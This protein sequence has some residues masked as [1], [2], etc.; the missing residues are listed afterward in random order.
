MNFMTSHTYITYIT[1]H[2]FTI[3]KLH[4][5][6]I[7]LC[8]L[9]PVLTKLCEKS[10]CPAES[11]VFLYSFET[12]RHVSI[13]NYHGISIYTSNT[14]ST[15][16]EHLML[17]G[18][19]KNSKKQNDSFTIFADCKRENSANVPDQ[20]SKLNQGCAGLNQGSAAQMLNPCNH[21]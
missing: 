11:K 19:N 1:C 9:A 17:L 2:V 16:D 21:C 20:G 3:L 15:F 14:V 10:R 4:H 5:L 18:M 6:A 12:I 7:T 13:K 8:Y